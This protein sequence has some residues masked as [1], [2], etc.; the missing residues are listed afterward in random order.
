MNCPSEIASIISDILQTGLLQ[1][2]AK[3]WS[4]DVQEIADIADYLHNLPGLLS[5]Y[6]PEKL[7]Y[8]WETERSGFLASVSEEIA[9]GYEDAWQRLE[10][11][12]V[13]HESEFRVAVTRN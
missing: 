7:H 9:A 6:S 11:Y 10:A 1:I 2:R 3:A 8:Y 13:E 5:D 4:N 12:M